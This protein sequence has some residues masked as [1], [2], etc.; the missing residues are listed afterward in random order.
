MARIVSLVPGFCELLAAIGLSSQLVGR[1][2]QCIHPASLDNVPALTTEKDRGLHG[3]VPEDDSPATVLSNCLAPDYLLLENLKD[4]KPDY[5]V[6]RLEVAGTSYTPEDIK[7]LAAE[8]LGTG[9]RLE[10]VEGM[11]LQSSLND[12]QRIADTFGMGNKAKQMLDRMHKR[13]E[14]IYEQAKNAPKR[15]RMLVLSSLDPLQ[16]AGNWVPNLLEG[17]YLEPVLVQQGQGT[18][19]ITW[20]QVI[21]EDPDLIVFALQGL[22]EAQAQEEVSHLHALPEVRTLRAYRMRKVFLV[23]AQRYLLPNGPS[24]LESCEILAEIS[25]PELFGRKRLGHSWLEMV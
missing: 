1:S 8:Y 15:R 21:A 5:V 17:S 19:R 25:Y 6:T 22:S 3:P 9:V 20:Q 2:H 18:R 7:K 12:M 23:D 16:A 4:A 24:L 13:M 11:D 14:Q 10:L